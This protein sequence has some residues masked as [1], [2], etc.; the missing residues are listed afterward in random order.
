[1]GAGFIAMVF[2]LSQL[3]NGVR[4]GSS[5]H[6]LPS[7]FFFSFHLVPK[8]LKVVYRNRTKIFFGAGDYMSSSNAVR[9]RILLLA[10]YCL[11]YLHECYPGGQVIL[12]PPR[13]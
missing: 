4:I 5:F 11:S 12:R 3:P 6:E 10:S 2:D 13:T 8:R 7:L 9:S 1:M